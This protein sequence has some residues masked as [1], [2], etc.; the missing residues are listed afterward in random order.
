[1]AV[2]EGLKSLT[3][4]LI[5]ELVRDAGGEE[6]KAK[7]FCINGEIVEIP[8]RAAL[9]RLPYEIEYLY[10]QPLMMVAIGVQGR[11]VDFLSAQTSD[12]LLSKEFGVGEG[13]V[14][15]NINKNTANIVSSLLSGKPIF[16]DDHDGVLR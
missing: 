11:E 12:M 15:E 14:L 13:R 5:D 4:E 2:A 8:L 9:Q 3:P 10:A 1:M 7:V 6:A 16:G